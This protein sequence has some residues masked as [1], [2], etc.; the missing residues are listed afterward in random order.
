MKNRILTFAGVCLAV[1]L[2]LLVSGCLPFPLGDPDKSQID[3]KLSGY[4]LRSSD[5]EREL[6]V[7]YPFDQHAYVLQDASAK[8][9]DDKWQP[10]GPPQIYKAWLTNVK[11]E[12]FITL[13]L[14][15]QRLPINPDDKKYYPVL[16]VSGTSDVIE[17]RMVSDTFEP[18]KTVK[19]SADV[20]AVIAR[21]LNN[22]DLYGNGDAAKFR[23]L[24][25]N[26]DKDLIDSV[27]A[28]N[29]SK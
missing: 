20:E 8:K 19:S 15:A 17:V 6:I 10:Q 29:S 24:D 2:A 26:A 18:M 16:H 27:L 22:P 13:E 25:V 23:R 14:L 1:G 5:D 11:G 3:P 28:N 12:R 9:Q 7:L 21:D 4:W